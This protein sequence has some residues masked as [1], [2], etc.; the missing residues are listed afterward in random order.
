MKK[1]ILFLLL[2]G[3]YSCSCFFQNEGTLI[4]YNE[5]KSGSTYRIEVDNIN[6]GTVPPGTNKSFTVPAGD[7]ILAIKFDHNGELAC[8][9]SV[10]NIPVCGS[11]SISCD[12]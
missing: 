5:S 9:Y 1:L 12:Q 7:R 3:F 8:S 4:I 6:Y 10:V 11:R 2:I